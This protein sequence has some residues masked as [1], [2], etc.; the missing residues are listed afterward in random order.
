ML[1]EYSPESY[2]NFSF[3]SGRIKWLLN[4]GCIFNVGAIEC[5]MQTLVPQACEKKR[6]SE[7]NGFLKTKIVQ[8]KENFPMFL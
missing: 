6:I 7:E 4:D 2:G 3:Y 1:A 5:E 8:L